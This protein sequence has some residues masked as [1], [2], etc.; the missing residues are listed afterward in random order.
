MATIALLIG[1]A[2][3]NATAF[4]VGSYLAR[5]LDGTHADVGKIRQSIREIATRHG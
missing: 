2:V 4:V 3:L 5:Y 1:G